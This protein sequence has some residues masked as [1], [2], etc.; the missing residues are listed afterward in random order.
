[1]EDM[2]F[3]CTAFNADLSG[4]DVSSVRDMTDMFKNTPALLTKPA[5]YT[6]KS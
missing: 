3:A 6:G 4:W 1:M 5:W 2:F